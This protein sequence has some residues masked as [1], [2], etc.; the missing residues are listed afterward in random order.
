MKISALQKEL[1]SAM[2]DNCQIEA[3]KGEI[4]I[5]KT[6]KEAILEAIEDYTLMME[7]C[8][9]SRDDINY[10]RYLSYRDDLYLL[11]TLNKQW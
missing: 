10:N 8:I 2:L 5:L 4:E 11:L 6:F 7:D 9:D 1:D 3:I